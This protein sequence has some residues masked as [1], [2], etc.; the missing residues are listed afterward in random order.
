ML[1]RIIMKKFA[2]LVL[3]TAVV[4]FAQSPPSGKS[5]SDAEKITSAMQA[6]PK[7]VT[8]SATVLDYPTSPDGEYRVLR[9]GTNG[10]TCL[11]G[12]AGAAHDEPGCFDQVFLQFI[13]DSTAGLTPNVQRI[14]ISYMYGGKWVPN[15]SHAMGSNAEFHVGPHI[16]IIGLDQK[17]LQTL[18]HDA[19]NGEPY[20]NSLP[21]RSELYLVIPIREWDDA[22]AVGAISAAHR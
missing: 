1:R 4:T 10:W 5:K 6:G 13:K 12:Y 14:G 17:T 16:M 22:Q 21:G 11:P 19:S 7:F 2:F 8:Q 15:K 20:V 9:A 18:N 3:I